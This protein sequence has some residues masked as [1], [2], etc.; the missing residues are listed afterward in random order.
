MFKIFNLNL[1][2]RR[3]TMTGINKPGNIKTEMASTKASGNPE[4]ITTSPVTDD[5]SKVTGKATPNTKSKQ[6]KPPTGK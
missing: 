2:Y 3:L 4:T 1:K 5:K 6:E